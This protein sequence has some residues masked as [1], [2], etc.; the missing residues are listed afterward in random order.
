MTYGKKRKYQRKEQLIFAY[1]VT[2]FPTIREAF[3]GNGSLVCPGRWHYKG[4]RVVYAS[5]SISLAEKEKITNLEVEKIPDFFYVFEVKIPVACID[6]IDSRNLPIGWN[7]KPGDETTANLGAAWYDRNEKAVLRVP[8]AL[9]PMECNYVLHPNQKGFSKLIIHRIYKLKTD[10]RTRY[11]REY[12]K[13]LS[14]QLNFPSGNST[15]P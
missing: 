1:R 14:S 9:L 11:T 13:H 7:E 6:E 5:N 8:S 15:A 12:V 2:Q 4:M 10:F 3:S